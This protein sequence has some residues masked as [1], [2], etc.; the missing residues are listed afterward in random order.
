MISSGRL[1]S[2]FA[3]YPAFAAAWPGFT[4]YK[5]KTCTE[6]LDI[7]SEGVPVPDSKLV[8]NHSITDWFSHAGGHYYDNL[9]FP[10]AMATGDFN[11][12]AGTQFVYWKADEPD[13]GCQF[14]LMKGTPRGW[15]ILNNMPGDEI[16]RV[17]NEGCYYT[18]LSP[19][20]DVI[21]SY[22]CGRDDCAMAEVEIQSSVS[23]NQDIVQ[24][25]NPPSCIVKNSYSA[26]P[27]IQD[28]KQIAVTRPQTCEAPP[29]C[30]HS[31]TQSRMFS[32]AIAHFQSFTWTTEE[33]VE[34]SIESGVDFIVDSKVSMAMSLNIA[35]SWMD[36]TGTTI[37][38]T[39]ITAAAEAGR[40]EAGTVAFYSF[41]PQYDCWEGDVS[42]GKDK[43]GNEKVLENI[44]FCQPRLA[45]TGDPAGI[46]RMVYTSG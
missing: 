14:I 43:D 28:G 19:N 8:I 27:T 6:K 32:T 11:T 36:E 41:T 45:T 33:G 9:T 35:Q 16:L 10:G 20:D 17:S 26:T 21:T 25:G 31:I 40:Q 24:G 5:E 12:D 34:V 42:C 46:F 23:Q 15:Q 39:N 30:T 1:L 13:I 4:A 37:T 38:Q 3:L 44:S 29:A 18:A 2:A 7:W 22:C